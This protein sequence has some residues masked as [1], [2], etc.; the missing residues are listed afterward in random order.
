MSSLIL[1][2]KCP[3]CGYKGKITYPAGH[4]PPECPEC[5]MQLII[6]KT[7]YK[8]TGGKKNE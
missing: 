3:V 4:T 7:S 5:Y 6:E 8:K 1:N 2:V